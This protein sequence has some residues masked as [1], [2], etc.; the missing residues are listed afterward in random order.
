MVD[1]AKLLSKFANPIAGVALNYGGSGEKIS[2]QT[3]NGIVTAIALNQVVSSKVVVFYTQLG[4]YC[5]GESNAVAIARTRQEF[6]KVRPRRGADE[7][8]EE[9]KIQVLIVPP[10]P[11]PI[12]NDYQGDLLI[13]GGDR[14]AISLA[15]SIRFVVGGLTNNGKQEYNAVYGNLDLTDEL[16]QIVS[17]AEQIELPTIDNE[18][19]LRLTDY[20]WIGAGLLQTLPIIEEITPTETITTTGTQLPSN[21]LPTYPKVSPPPNSL[22]IGTRTINRIVPNKLNYN[23]QITHDWRQIVSG[24]SI[25]PLPNTTAGQQISAQCDFSSVG[26]Y[27]EYEYL[28]LNR[29]NYSQTISSTENL[30]ARTGLNEA[31]ESAYSNTIVNCTSLITRSPSSFRT[32]SAYVCTQTGGI[33]GS[34][35]GLYQWQ[36][37]GAING[38][39]NGETESQTTTRSSSR[40]LTTNMLLGIFFNPQTGIE[41]PYLSL[42]KDIETKNLTQNETIAYPAKTW[43]VPLNT[44]YFDF[45]VDGTHTRI[46]TETTV[47]DRLIPSTLII[48]RENNFWL[49]ESAIDKRNENFTHNFTHNT[50]KT[51]WN[52][53]QTFNGRVNDIEIL[54][55]SNKEVKS[56]YYLVVETEFVEISID[57]SFLINFEG[58][59]EFDGEGKCKIENINLSPLVA[60]P[61]QY[62]SNYTREKNFVT[63][64]TTYSN[65]TG[66]DNPLFDILENKEVYIFTRVDEICYLYICEIEEYEFKDSL[67]ISVNTIT[68][69][70]TATTT[71]NKFRSILIGD[72]VTGTGIPNWTV[73]T[74]KPDNNTLILSR[75]S[76]ATGSNNLT[77]TSVGDNP[78]VIRRVES[79]TVR[80]IE[81]TEFPYFTDLVENGK[82]II[83]SADNCNKL[84]FDL[85]KNKK[86]YCNAIDN[87][88]VTT[89]TYC[90]IP[91]SLFNESEQYVMQFELVDGVSQQLEIKDTKFIGLDI[92]EDDII[93][94]TSSDIF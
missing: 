41:E 83:Y 52:N 17:N 37:V 57:D 68:N 1:I 40:N 55:I 74:S 43:V 81:T 77:F 70:A 48:E 64:T 56:K 44:Y 39:Y 63:S 71:D 76:T 85:L 8:I 49:V 9:L 22:A 16:Q 60:E 38:Y 78:E 91:R 13:L 84:V 92:A 66:I 51:L 45:P 82:G 6:V 54:T 11:D 73:V 20:Y 26:A 69:S 72:T 18:P 3:E 14:A 94:G 88:G 61:R 24:N 15:D 65:L 21:V 80:E 79:I 7:I 32:V 67:S 89:I 34:P 35:F 42:Y 47:I 4:A 5:L 25:D 36:S 53:T 30:T 90:E 28:R 12:P 19:A 87:N 58:K 29:F 27:F 50:R 93:V 31:I 59:I 33:S 10:V 23:E 86:K 46:K 75:S 62:Y 2:I